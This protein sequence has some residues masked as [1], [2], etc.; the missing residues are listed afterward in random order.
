MHRFCALADDA[1]LQLNEITD[2]RASTNVRFRAQ[3]RK[4]SDDNS[5]VEAARIHHAVRFYG[6]VVG[7]L[8]IGQ[9]TSSA[10]D[11]ARTNAR[12][13]KKLHAGLDSSVLANLHVGINEHS[14]R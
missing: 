1:V 10:N 2:A 3:P 12:F 14:F 9:H 6:H 5:S 13:P 8:R 11:A 7:Q 4:W